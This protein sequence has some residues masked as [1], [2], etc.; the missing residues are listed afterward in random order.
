M[1]STPCTALRCCLHRAPICPLP[2]L[3][4]AVGRLPMIGAEHSG[5]VGM[6]APQLFL[7]RHSL[8]ERMGA[9]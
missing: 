7:G 4:R 9:P 6:G 3:L 8:T 1:L 5:L 2:L